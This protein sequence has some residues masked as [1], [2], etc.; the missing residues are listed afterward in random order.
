MNEPLSPPEAKQIIREI[1]ERGSVTFSKH[2]LREM[3][4]DELTTVDCVNILR[5]GVVEQPELENNSWRYRVHSSRIWVVAAFRSETEVVVV[6]AWRE[7]R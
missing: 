4:D 5:A 3:A 1:L 2:A 7:K 6:T